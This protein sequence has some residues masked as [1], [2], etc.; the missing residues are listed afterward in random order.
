[1]DAV[2]ECLPFQVL[3]DDERLAL[4]LPDVVDSADV[5]MIQCQ[6]CSGLSLETL[7]CLAIL[8]KLLRQELA[9]RTKER[10]SLSIIEPLFDIRPLFYFVA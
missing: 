8:G 3:H 9:N 10:T 7:Q 1:L 4:M 6:C 2:F 5:G